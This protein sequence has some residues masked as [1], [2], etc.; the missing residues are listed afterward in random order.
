MEGRL[1]ALDIHQKHLVKEGNV[2]Y[3]KTF[4]PLWENLI[5]PHGG[6]LDILYSRLLRFAVLGR[7]DYC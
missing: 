5:Y 3:C 4:R 1:T 6:S 7:R 2:F